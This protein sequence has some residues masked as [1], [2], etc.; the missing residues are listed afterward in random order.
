GITEQMVIH[1]FANLV[2]KSLEEEYVSVIT[3]GGRY[4]SHFLKI[5]DKDNE[6]AIKK[7]ITFITDRDPKRQGIGKNS[8][9]EKC[10]AASLNINMKKVI[11]RFGKIIENFIKKMQRTNV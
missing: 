5:F 1:H 6:N 10:T 9:R 7:R 8:D 3:L 4:T 11:I 2:G